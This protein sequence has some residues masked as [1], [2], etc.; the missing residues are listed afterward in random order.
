ML[1]VPEAKFIGGIPSTRLLGSEKLVFQF[2]VRN[3]LVKSSRKV[4]ERILRTR[5]CAALIV[6]WYSNDAELFDDDNKACTAWRERLASRRQAPI[7][8]Y[9]YTAQQKGEEQRE[10][11]FMCHRESYLDNFVGV[12]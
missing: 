7:L 4:V 8:R 12:R 11:R 1:L 9:R 3:G 10:R 2:R 5:L 6:Q